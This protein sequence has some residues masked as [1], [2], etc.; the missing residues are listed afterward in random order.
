MPFYINPRLINRVTLEPATDKHPPRVF[1][2]QE[3]G[4]PV[5]VPLNDVIE[6]VTLFHALRETHKYLHS[7]NDVQPRV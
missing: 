5:F 2:H 1:F 7:F 4:S 3:E 6:A